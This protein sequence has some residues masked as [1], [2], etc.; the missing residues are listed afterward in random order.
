M[1]RG[2]RSSAEV[3]FY[4]CDIECFMCIGY[5]GE[6]R[7]CNINISFFYMYANFGLKCYWFKNGCVVLLYNWSG[8]ESDVLCMNQRPAASV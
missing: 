5:K 4:C 2:R 7:I 3:K 8:V 1:E 6:F